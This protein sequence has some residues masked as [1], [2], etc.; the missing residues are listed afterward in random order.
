VIAVLSA[1][2]AG[3]SKQAGSARPSSPAKITISEPKPG[4]AVSG[5]T[6][7]VKIELNGGTIVKKT[8]T[9]ITPTTE[10]HV[11][12]SV[13][14]KILTM[15]YGPTQR[16]DTPKRGRHLLQVEF[17]AKDHGPFNPR[18]LASVPFEVR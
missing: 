11:H 18:V 8:T 2:C 9:N 3:S 12:L 7:T 5:K 14:G 4:Q 6:F 10:G 17:V 15:T 1:A 13:D 16:L